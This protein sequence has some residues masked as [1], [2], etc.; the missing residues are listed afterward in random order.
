MSMGEGGGCVMSSCSRGS[1]G[2][3]AQ[4][5]IDGLEIHAGMAS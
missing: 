4:G 3:P 5:W 2:H 1:W